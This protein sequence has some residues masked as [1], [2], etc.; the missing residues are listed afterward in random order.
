MTEYSEDDMATQIERSRSIVR[1]GVIRQILDNAPNLV[2]MDIKF[3]AVAADPDEVFAAPAV[4][5]DVIPLYR[6]WPKLKCLFLRGIECERQEIAQFLS[7]HKTS[8]EWI[9]IC[10]MQLR[11]TS[12]LEFLPNI[13]SILEDSSVDNIF[14]TGEI[15]GVSEDD[16]NRIRREAWDLMTPENIGWKLDPVVAAIQAYVLSWIGGSCPLTLSRQGLPSS[17]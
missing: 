1:Q 16:R 13:R 11:S 14:F 3:E 7:R 4:L 8:L 15:K 5:S 12:W 10:G 2:N 17:G 6:V 9:R